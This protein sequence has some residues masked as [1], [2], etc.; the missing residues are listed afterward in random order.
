VMSVAMPKRY[1]SGAAV[2]KAGVPDPF[3]HS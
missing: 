2:V 3:A 1:R